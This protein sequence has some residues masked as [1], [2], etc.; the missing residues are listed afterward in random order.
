MLNQIWTVILGSYEQNPAAG[1]KLFDH[2]PFNLVLQVLG[3]EFFGPLEFV[4]GPALGM[5][6]EHHLAREVACFNRIDDQKKS[7][8]IFANLKSEIS[9]LRFEI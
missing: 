6:G 3:D 7:A 2:E 1:T 5:E 8:I 4:V 9:N